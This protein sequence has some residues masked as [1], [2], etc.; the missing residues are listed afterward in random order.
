MGYANTVLEFLDGKSQEEIRLLMLV[1]F[2]YAKRKK[3]ARQDTVQFVKE[4]L[5]K[6]NPDYSLITEKE[7]R[8]AIEILSHLD[9]ER[10]CYMPRIVQTLPAVT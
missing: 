10:V 6:Y 8:D 9:V 5:T 1:E 2:W 7:V 4:K 3:S